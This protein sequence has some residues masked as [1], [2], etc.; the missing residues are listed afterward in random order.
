MN[1][2]QPVEFSS[3]KREVLLDFDYYFDEA[4]DLYGGIQITK[5]RLGDKTWMAEQSK[6]A[7]VRLTFGRVQD[8]VDFLTLSYSAG[9]QVRELRE[10]FPDV[11]A[12][13]EE[14]FLFDL[15][16]KQ[17]EADEKKPAIYI[18]TSD[19]TYAN[20]LLCFA[21]LLGW[22]EYIPQIMTIVN[23]NNPLLDGMLENI[24]SQFMPS[25]QPLPEECVR[26]L[27]YFK[28]LAIFAA[29]PAERSDLMRNYLLDWYDASRR[30]SYYNAHSRGV[31]FHGYWSWEAGAITVALDID[32][33]SYRNLPFYPRDM[34]D[35]ARQM[36]RPAYLDA[37]SVAVS[38][39]RVKAGEPC[40]VQGAWQSIGMPT[41]KMEFDQGIPMPDLQSPYGLTVWK[42]IGPIR[43]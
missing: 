29:A 18:Q 20:R 32:D 33:Q 37:H 28:T 39:L 14:F 17:A 8:T 19:Y 25:T 13:L 10:L 26:H 35:F 42:Y 30:E 43:T 31:P 2:I 41:E 1:I 22:S 11:V 38:D 3:V 4:D 36:A 23:Y 12:Y 27:P 16:R 6:P 15:A 21:V 34:V 40:P 24:A 7:L 9:V 5:E